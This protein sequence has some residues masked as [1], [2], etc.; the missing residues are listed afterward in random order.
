MTPF[1]FAEGKRALDDIDDGLILPHD[2]PQ[3]VWYID[4]IGFGVTLDPDP[5]MPWDFETEGLELD[6]C[7]DI[8]VSAALLDAA[9]NGTDDSADCAGFAAQYQAICA[10]LKAEL[11]RHKPLSRK[12]KYDIPGLRA[13]ACKALSHITCDYA[14]TCEEMGDSFPQFR[15]AVSALI[16]RLHE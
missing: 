4:K 7:F 5:D 1:R 13:R 15:D 9:L 10:A 12:P 8:W 14:E 6:I 11:Q 3:I 16:A 2:A